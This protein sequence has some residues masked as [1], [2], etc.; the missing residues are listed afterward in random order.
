MC[1]KF[2]GN[3]TNNSDVLKEG[4]GRYAIHRHLPTQIRLLKCL[5]EIFLIVALLK[6]ALKHLGC[7]FF[8]KNLNSRYVWL[9]SEYTCA[10]EFVVSFSKLCIYLGWFW[11][12][13]FFSVDHLLESNFYYYYYH[14][15][16]YYYDYYYYYYN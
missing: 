6:D 15:C 14:Y 7:N 5:A 10:F 2:Q 1:S 9:A 11:K 16:Y 13:H 8:A 4:E 3:E 12:L